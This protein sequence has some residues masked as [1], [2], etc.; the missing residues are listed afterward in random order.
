MK[1]KIAV[2]EAQLKEIKKIWEYEEK[3]RYKSQKYKN[4]IKK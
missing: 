1:E 2:I 3:K 4:F